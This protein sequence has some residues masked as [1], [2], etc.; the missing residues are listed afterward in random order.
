MHRTIGQSVIVPA[1]NWR[2]QVY[3]YQRQHKP[4]E[5]A[6]SAAGKF[7]DH[8]KSVRMANPDIPAEKKLIDDVLDACDFH[9]IKNIPYTMIADTPVLNAASI[10]G[11]AFVFTTGI[12]NTMPEASLRAVVG[13]E[14]G[15]H[16][17]SR[18]DTL[19]FS[20]IIFASFAANIAFA[21]KIKAAR[22]W[23][24]ANIKPFLKW[25]AIVASEV[26]LIMAFALPFT[27]FRWNAE[28]ESDRE[29]A[30]F[31]SPDAMADALQYL[32]SQP[33]AKHTQEDFSI[34]RIFWRAL[35]FLTF[36]FG[37]HPPIDSRI[38]AMRE[39]A[40][41]HASSHHSQTSAAPLTSPAEHE[42]QRLFASGAPPAKLVSGDRTASRLT[43]EEA[44]LHPAS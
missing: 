5:F 36:P 34:G 44:V 18:R 8:V 1:P 31:S 30:A 26:A 12:M 19:T 42:T 11:K 7:V 32:K 28:R 6:A 43:P 24:T 2:E 22:S 14:M 16:K 40:A 21:E 10:G 38:Q 9:G 25:P 3:A 39:L 33:R 37:S 23:M 27:P 13:H 41:K 29:G 20:G 35:H 17:N 15:H 4:D